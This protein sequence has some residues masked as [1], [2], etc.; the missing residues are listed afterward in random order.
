MRASERLTAL[1]LAALG[2]LALAGR[3]PSPGV[4]LALAALLAAT[5]LLARRA[6]TSAAGAPVRDF[7]P[8][9]TVVAVFMLLEPVI[10]GVNPRRFDAV[11]QA[12]DAR[13]FPDLGPAWRNAFDRAPAF[14]DLTYLVYVSY[15]ALPIL[16]V[17][18]ARRRGAAS[19]EAAV[20]AL[21]LAFYGSF[22]GY[23]LFPTSGP[24]LLPADEARVV[25]GGAI[26]DAVRSFLHAAEK[27]RLDAFPSGHTCIAL[28]S[29]AVGARA[30]PRR[31]PAL[32]AWAG[33]VV[34]STVYVHV[35][36]VVD[37][38][39][40]AALAAAALGAA[41]AVGRALARPGGR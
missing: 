20:L 39:A 30:A 41:P 35:H 15:Y 5:V 1:F 40:G 38:V 3:P 27:T 19:F 34:F 31:A 17:A 33:A 14:T 7:F 12:L 13:W 26:A 36:Y 29:A 21:L 11:F 37:V 18:L 8:V 28:V 32:L 6:P 9:V 4:A 25:G 16:A 22:V 24:R 10:V 23:L 2:V